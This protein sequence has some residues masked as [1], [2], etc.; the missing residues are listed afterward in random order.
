M[1]PNYIDSDAPDMGSVKHPFVVITSR[2][3]LNRSGSTC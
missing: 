1:T 2:S 3:I